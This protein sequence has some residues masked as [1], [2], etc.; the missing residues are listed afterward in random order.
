MQCMHETRSGLFQDMQLVIV[1]LKHS[2]FKLPTHVQV[3]HASGRRYDIIE[4]E[5]QVH[6]FII[7]SNLTTESQI[8]H[9]NS[10]NNY[11]FM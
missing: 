2:I 9:Q 6:S 10:N 7:Y 1:D 8:S 11:F 5:T 4:Q 3:D